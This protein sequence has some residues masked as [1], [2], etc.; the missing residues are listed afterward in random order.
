MITTI[1]DTIVMVNQYVKLIRALF[2]TFA[3]PVSPFLLTIAIH[4]G[5]GFFKLDIVREPSQDV[6]LTV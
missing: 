1:V 4:G 2:P 5:G 6:K 3:G